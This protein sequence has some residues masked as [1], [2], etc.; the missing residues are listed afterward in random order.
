[1][2][3]DA[4]ALVAGRDEP[5]DQNH[6][7]AH[8]QADL[9]EHGDER[10]ATTRIFGSKPGSYGADIR[11]HDGSSYQGRTVKDPSLAEDLIGDLDARGDG[12]DYAFHCADKVVGE[13]EI[14]G[15]RDHVR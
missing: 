13:A 14:G 2:L 10:R 6:V 8:A 4:V 7:R 3:D 11:G 12:G 9:A 5:T 1:M 15:E